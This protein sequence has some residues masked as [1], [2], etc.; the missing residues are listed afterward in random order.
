VPG[1]PPRQRTGDRAAPTPPHPARARASG[2][3]S[4]PSYAQKKRADADARKRQRAADERGRR[5]SDLEN[6]IAERERTIKN[7]EAQMAAPGFYESRDAA[8]DVVQ[9]H[10]QLMWEVGDL[11]NQWEALAAGAADK[12]A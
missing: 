4:S 7:L 6:R 2:S 10:Q 11:M 3:E 5:I 9:R 1:P 12:E 8:A